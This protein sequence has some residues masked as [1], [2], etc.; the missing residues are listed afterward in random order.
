MLTKGR[1][2]SA[3]KQK[4]GSMCG[5][6]LAAGLLVVGVV[7]DDGAEFGDGLHEV[8]EAVVPFGGG[9]EEKHNSLMREADLEVSDLADVT[10]E[11]LRIFELGDLG[12]GEVLFADL[13]EEN[14]DVFL[15]EDDLAHSEEGGTGGFGVLDEILPAVGGLFLV[16]DGG[17]VFGDVGWEAAHAVA[18]DEG[19]HVVFERDEVVGLHL[20]YFRRLG[21]ESGIEG[22]WVTRG[23]EFG[24]V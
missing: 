6:R 18:G 14:G 9:F 4:L 17:D 8:L 16:D 10:D 22:L 15:S 13:L 11:E 2:E 1:V 24:G 19:D 21:R 23:G 7:D 5:P 12:V 20:P 3:P